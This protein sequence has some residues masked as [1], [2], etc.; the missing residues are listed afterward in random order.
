MQSGLYKTDYS[1]AYLE[2]CFVKPMFADLPGKERRGKGALCWRKRQKKSSEKRRIGGENELKVF[3]S[4]DAVLITQ[5]QALC[6]GVLRHIERAAAGRPLQRLRGIDMQN[7]LIAEKGKVCRFLF[8][9]MN[10]DKLIHLNGGQ[11][12]SR[13]VTCIGNGI[14]RVVDTAIGIQ[15]P[16]DLHRRQHMRHGAGS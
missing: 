7:G 15:K 1:Y 16:I 9:Q 14:Q 10:D 8:M 12:R 13:A 6:D 5:G 3:Q 2:Y 11:S 4:L